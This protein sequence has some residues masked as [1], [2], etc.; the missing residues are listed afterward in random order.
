MCRPEIFAPCDLRG[1][2]RWRSRSSPSGRE[3]GLDP[4]PARSA[5]IDGTMT[6]RWRAAGA[7]TI[8]HGPDPRVRAM[9]WYWRGVT[10]ADAYERYVAH[11]RRAPPRLR[12]PD[13]NGSSGSDKYA[14]Q[15][16]KPH[17]ALLLITR[18]R[19]AAPR[20]GRAHSTGGRA[21]SMRQVRTLDN[22]NVPTFDVTSVHSRRQWVAGTGP[23]GCALSDPAV[24]TPAAERVAPASRPRSRHPA[25][26]ATT[27][28][29]DV[30]NEEAADVSPAPSSTPGDQRTR[31]RR[32]PSAGR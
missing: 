30:Q 31:P 28:N 10:G 5:P 18:P 9:R 29:R 19:R 4:T 23:A 3:A 2:R 7:D 13:K 22:R 14:D 25:A 17:P 1:H 21:H 6:S 20:G 16:R 11:L 32:P 12:R 15:E 24:T 8:G 26:T 27:E